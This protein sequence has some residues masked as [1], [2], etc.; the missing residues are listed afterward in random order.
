MCFG[1]QCT[2]KSRYHRYVHYNWL[3][4]WIS[5]TWN[6]FHHEVAKLRRTWSNPKLN[7][8]SCRDQSTGEERRLS[9]QHR[10]D[11]GTCIIYTTM[12]IAGSTASKSPDAPY[13]SSLEQLDAWFDQPSRH[14]DNVLPYR[15]LNRPSTNAT[16]GR[17]LVRFASIFLL[18]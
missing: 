7:N 1:T 16:T 18:R 14:L 17:L 15:P 3:L 10:T 5:T 8:N 6:T 9:R 13:F 2:E 4:E 11:T 12:P